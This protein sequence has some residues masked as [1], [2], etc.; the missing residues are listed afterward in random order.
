MVRVPSSRFERLLIRSRIA[1]VFQM[2]A[3]LNVVTT[4]YACCPNCGESQAFVVSENQKQSG[5]CG[6]TCKACHHTYDGKLDGE[7]W[8]LTFV[9]IEQ[10]T[11]VLL[12]IPPQKKPV[13]FVVPHVKSARL[14]GQVGSPESE[15]HNRFH[16][17][18][19]CT[20]TNHIGCSAIIGWAGNYLDYSHMDLFRYIAEVPA[21]AVDA[22]DAE[23]EGKFL[24][25]FAPHN[26]DM[27]EA[28]IECNLLQE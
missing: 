15:E 27:K 3:K 5:R 20:M 4:T 28:A 23:D 22:V 1:R 7:D 10:Q 2:K 13:Y 8:E 9:G 26:A 16:F 14:G 24:A 11:F 25:A 18:E 21:E 19:N 17:E 12:S 6:G